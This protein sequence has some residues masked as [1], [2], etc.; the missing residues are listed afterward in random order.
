[1][2]HREG[3]SIVSI[4]NYMGGKIATEHLLGLGHQRI[5]HISGPLDWWESCQRKMGWHDALEAAG[6][7][8]ED[9]FCVEGTWSPRS[10]E[11]AFRVLLDQY[12][13]MDSVFVANDQ[14]ALSVLQVACKENIKIPNDLAVVGFDNISEAAYFWPP[15]TT[16]HQNL[17]NLGCTAVKELISA[18]RASR[19]DQLDI[20]TKNLFLKPELIIRQSTDPNK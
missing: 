2:E 6:I 3:I 5:A 18:I 8:P 15:L 9:H 13:E 16:L 7:Q 4:D 14:M 10:G 17:Q 1:M 20:E 19:D 12:P 11:R